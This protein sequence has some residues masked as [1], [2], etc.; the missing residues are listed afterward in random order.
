MLLNLLSKLV[1]LF[2]IIISVNASEVKSQKVTF[3]LQW[4]HQFEFAGFYMAKEKGFYKELGLDVEFIEFK[5]GINI[6]DEV[7]SQRADYGVGY[8]SIIV[9][10]LN[11]KPIVFVANFFKQSPLVLVTQK[12]ITSVS[13]LRGTKIEGLSNNIDN[14]TLYTMLNKFDLN[15]ND[16]ETLAPTFK[17]DNFINKKVDAMTAFTTNE[18]YLLDIAGIKY[19]IFDPVTYGTKYYDVNL[20]TSKK[21]VLNN[22]Q[23]V[24]NFRQAS[25]KGWIYALEHKTETVELILEKYNT[26]NKSKESLLFEAKQIEQVML[27][28]VHKVGSIDIDRVKIIADNFIHSGFVQNDTKYNINDFLFD[29]KTYQN[30]LTNDDL[31]YIKE[32]KNIKICVD[33]NWMPIEAIIDSRHVGISSDYWKI[34]E[35]KLGVEVKVFKTQSWSGSLEAMRQEKCDVLSLSTPT[36]Q[37][38]KDIK[39]TKPLL[40]LS[41]I[42]IS[43]VDKKSVID[44]SMLDGLSVAVVKDYALVN[45]IREKYPKINIVEVRNINEGLEKV[46]RGEVFGLA[47][48]A[49]AID[50]AYNNGVYSDFKVSAYFDEKLQLSLGIAKGNVKLYNI[51]EKIVNSISEEQ[52]QDIL[53]KWF[54]IKYEKQ[55]DYSLFWKLIIFILIIIFIVIYRQYNI[56]K[57]NKELTKRVQDELEKSRDKDKMIF[58][59]SKLAAMGEMIENITHQWRQPLSQVNSAVLVIDDILD[60]NGIRNDL[61]EEK[62]QEIESL[63][64]Y[65]SNT[66]ND[67]KNFFDKNKI[68]SDFIIEDIL[69]KSLEVLDTKLKSNNIKIVLGI[70]AKHPCFGYPTELQQ[71]LLIILNNAIDALEISNKVNLEIQIDID[72][73]D[74]HNYIRI[75]DNAGGMN[76]DIEDKIFEP[77]YTT[78]HKTQGTGLGLYIAKVII[79]DSMGGELRVRTKSGGASFTIKLKVKDE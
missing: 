42:I 46:D 8:S 28:K 17:M 7:L 11:A 56:Q 58:H 21:E 66:I 18:L 37:R 2:F 14:I 45:I 30:F 72:K 50:Y 76:I 62:L 57:Q 41:F 15:E 19:N 60:E 3:Q 68:K 5:N 43:L 1:L 67:F 49:V 38:S 10:Y 78:K 34:I 29:I 25:I 44:F 73:I 64:K 26:Q 55:F 63:T 9:D 22:P 65:M 48:S 20:F 71:V 13:Q 51:F 27:P 33:P 24:K 4:K 70:R 77:Y 6:V 32:L 35:K 59:Q 69:D 23:R 39:F 16:I 75:R 40:D 31:K 36:K 54:S 12:D 79:E 53:K 61:V 52:K 47:D 74:S